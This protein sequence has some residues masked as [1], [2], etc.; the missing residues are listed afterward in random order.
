M[1]CNNPPLSSLVG[2][3]RDLKPD[4]KWFRDSLGRYAMFRGVNFASSSKLPPYY[5]PILPGDDALPSL[6]LLKQL[7]INVVRLLVSWKKLAPNPSPPP[8]DSPG[9][10][11]PAG[12]EYLS[13]LCD[14]IEKLYEQD[15]FVLVD[16]HQDIAH[17]K[18]GGD[19]FP[20]WAI[21]VDGGHPRPKE[22]PRSD[23]AWALR[24]FEFPEVV[25][26]LPFIFNMPTVPLPSGDSVDL[27]QLVRATLRSFWLNSTTNEFGTINTQDQ[28]V[29][30]IQAVAI[31]LSSNP[32]VLGYEPF[33][34]P[35]PVG[36]GKKCFEERYLTPYY[37]AVLR[38]VHSVDPKAFIFCEPRVDWNSLPTK[39]GG[40]QDCPHDV[41]EPDFQTPILYSL[42]TGSIKTFV[43]PTPPAV[44]A[45]AVFSFH[46]YDPWTDAYG[47]AGLCDMMT[48]KQSEWPG[49]FKKMME[50]AH[51]RNMVPFLTEFGGSYGWQMES[52]LGPYKI[53]IQTYLDLMY[54][55]IENNLLNSI[56]WV[57][58]LHYSD[59]AGDGWND[60]RFSL[61]GPDQRIQP[62]MA[63]IVARPYPMRSSALPK[64]LVFDSS[65]SQGAIL[66]APTPVSS[67]PT[68]IYV[69]NEFHYP[70]GFEV[71]ATGTDFHWNINNHVLAWNLGPEGTNADHQMII[72]PPGKFEPTVLPPEFL[73]AM[74]RLSL[75]R[76]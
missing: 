64:S 41:D 18:Y 47:I 37:Q 61:L 58:D 60:E 54:Q 30:T 65:R 36:L 17:E 33:N 44:E 45:R 59:Q 20:D 1:S 26:G 29:W 8:G 63:P 22:P 15:I 5:L 42:G 49:I 6:K 69:P 40:E 32:A 9:S 21:V 35:H 19:G 7:G 48:N 2:G 16:F 62:G 70:Q 57:Y 34:E 12:Q 3:A 71:H 31:A 39:N 68:L 38:R 10:L 56:L 53:Q 13:S 28:L 72:C 74:D 43:W 46:F 55:Q 4:G 25:E 23:P 50:A 73:G 67:E 24:L 66:L 76:F 14:V 75:L 51:A 11:S 27:N 52:D